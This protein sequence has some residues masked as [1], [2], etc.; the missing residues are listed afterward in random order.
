M[1]SPLVIVSVLSLFSCTHAV[2]LGARGDDCTYCCPK[3]DVYGK[4]L[5][6]SSPVD[7]KFICCTY[8]GDGSYGGKTDTSC[9]YDIVRVF[10]FPIAY[11][12]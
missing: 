11:F 8:D 1:F 2:A 10:S 6:T 12:C 5:S 3:T 4:T 7:D 9:T